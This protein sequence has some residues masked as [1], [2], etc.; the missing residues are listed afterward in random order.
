MDNILCKKEKFFLAKWFVLT[1]PTRYEYKKNLNSPCV[2]IRELFISFVI[3]IFFSFS[4]TSIKHF[5]KS[6]LNKHPFALNHDNIYVFRSMF[7]GSVV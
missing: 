5:S 4:S 6:H 1:R 7:S 2:Y 3:I